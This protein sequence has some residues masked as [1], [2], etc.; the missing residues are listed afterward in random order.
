MDAR[1]FALFD[2]A[3]G[4]CAIA[5]SEAGL[6]GVQLPEENDVLA[7]RRLARRFPLTL[8][9][10]RWDDPWLLIGQSDGAH[11]TAE[12][13]H[14]SS[15]SIPPPLRRFTSGPTAEALQ[16]RRLS[17]ECSTRMSY[18]RTLSGG[19]WSDRCAKHQCDPNYS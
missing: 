18:D 1:G 3:I 13:T 14:L 7:E 2:T 6:I 10:P 5:W 11:R 8:R 19:R 4:R 12:L 15:G 17:C 9:L 16:R